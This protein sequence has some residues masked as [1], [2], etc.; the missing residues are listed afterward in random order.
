MIRN[1]WLYDVQDTPAGSGYCI[2]GVWN[3]NS[4]VVKCA[5]NSVSCT[6]SYL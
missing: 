6:D 5:R 3:L 2:V 4:I 1:A